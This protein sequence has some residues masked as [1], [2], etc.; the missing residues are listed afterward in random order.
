[1]KRIE[2]IKCFDMQLRSERDCLGKTNLLIW[3]L[4]TLTWPPTPSLASCSL[5]TLGSI[6][7]LNLMTAISERRSGDPRLHRRKGV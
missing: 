4:Y 1:M 6:W 3:L 5:V 2:W 7:I